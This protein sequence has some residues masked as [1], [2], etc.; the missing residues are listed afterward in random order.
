M[1]KDLPQ[2]QP[3][4]E[5]DLG[6]LF[7]LIGNAFDRF[8]KFIGSIFKSLFLA[9][10]WLVF[11]VKTHILK[12]IIAGV[13][14]IAV[15]IFLEK[16]SDPMYKSY[17]TIKQNYGTGENLYNSISYY[18]DLVSQ[19]DA[20]TLKNILNIQESEANSI[21]GFDIEP[22][23][24]ENQKLQNFDAYIK[25]LDSAVASKVKY[26]T[27]VKNSQDFSYEFQQISIQAKER[28]N[29][30]KVFEK[31][32]ENI[33]KNE[34]FERE[35][36]K[37]LAELKETESS[38]LEA[39]KQSDSLQKTYK[40]VLEKVLDKT[41]GSQTSI[42]IEGANEIDKTKEFELYKSDLLLRDRLVENRRRQADKQFV[43][44]ILSS[45]QDSGVIDNSK[46]IFG[47]H[48]SVKI[49]Y[50]ILF[51]GLTF[52]VLLGLHFIKFLEKYKNQ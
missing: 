18:N 49:Y 13:I 45:K 2:P 11:F 32:I 40:R 39:L 25:T 28:N 51:V 5:V 33:N 27:F 52:M 3:S 36:E 6:Q 22:V 48:V 38:L 9:F 20:K 44:E 47:K 41:N 19:R 30:K 16:T 29:F 1:S 12:F 26:E 46:M 31:I 21:L 15:G 42:V 8:F 14:G 43:V 37:D 35:Q 23:V 34:F 10:V 24:T 7:K 17:I 4:E 50:I